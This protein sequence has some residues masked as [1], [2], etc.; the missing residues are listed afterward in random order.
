VLAWRSSELEA[1]RGE[2]Q[3]RC[4]ALGRVPTGGRS[5]RIY[6]EGAGRSSSA[7]RSRPNDLL[8]LRKISAGVT[9]GHV[10]SLTAVLYSLWRCEIS[11]RDLGQAEHLW[12]WCLLCTRIAVA[13][14]HLK[15]KKT[16]RVGLERMT[17][18]AHRLLAN[19]V[20]TPSIPSH[21]ILHTKKK[22]LE[23]T[24]SSNQARAGMIPSQKIGIG[25]LPHF[26]PKPNTTLV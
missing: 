17:G 16:L 7:W 1:S 24:Y 23:W 10:R 3:R 5:S 25:S 4:G 19:G 18:G 22:K 12:Q 6:G 26:V 13:G 11:V 14:A 2:G 20:K 15:R 8:W 9:S 21:L